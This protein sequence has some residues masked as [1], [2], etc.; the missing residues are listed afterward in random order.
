LK[1]VIATF[2]NEKIRT[3]IFIETNPEMIRNAVRTNTDRIELYTE[4]YARNFP[5]NREE[6]IK[7]FKEAAQVANQLGLG[8]NAGHDLD[9]DNLKFFAQ[10]IPGLLEVSIGHAMISDALYFGLENTIQLYLRQLRV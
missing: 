3:S 4:S 10:N 2:H 1:D 6:A 9:L 8:L 5:V 7:P